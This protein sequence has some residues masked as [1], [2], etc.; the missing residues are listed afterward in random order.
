MSGK[1]AICDGLTIKTLAEM[2]SLL[3]LKEF[4]VPWKHN[5]GHTDFDEEGMKI[6]L[7]GRKTEREMV[8]RERQEPVRLGEA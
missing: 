4:R 6:S 3:W 2:C 5:A 1:C 8:S 7:C